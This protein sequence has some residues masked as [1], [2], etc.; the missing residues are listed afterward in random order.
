MRL[1]FWDLEVA[2]WGCESGPEKLITAR[3]YSEHIWFPRAP[4]LSKSI[5]RFPSQPVDSIWKITFDFGF[6]RV[7]VTFKFLFP[8]S[9]AW[10]SERNKLDHQHLAQCF[11]PFFGNVWRRRVGRPESDEEEWSRMNQKKRSSDWRKLLFTFF[12]VCRKEI[13]RRKR[14]TISWEREEEE[15]ER[16]NLNISRLVRLVFFSPRTNR[17]LA[18]ISS[19]YDSFV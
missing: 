10:A 18:N 11:W 15:V 6:S 9:G 17:A 5:A 3:D 13:A 1:A 7:T 16:F 8:Q 12:F 4:P 2:Q 19:N 14:R